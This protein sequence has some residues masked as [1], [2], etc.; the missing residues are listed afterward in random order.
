MAHDVVHE[1][2]LEKVENQTMQKQKD[3]DLEKFQHT[4]SFLPSGV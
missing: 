2:L 3:A 1:F 4:E